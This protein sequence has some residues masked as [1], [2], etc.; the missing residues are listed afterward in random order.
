M[1]LVSVDGLTE[2]G[3]VSELVAGQFS[4]QARY[5]HQPVS[6]QPTVLGQIQ[7]SGLGGALGIKLMDPPA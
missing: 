6:E 1:R 3:D 4:D 5:C 7:R 2:A